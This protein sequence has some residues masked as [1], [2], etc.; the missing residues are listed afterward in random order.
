MKRYSIFLCS[1]F[2]LVFT[3]AVNANA[4]PIQGIPTANGSSDQ[5]GTVNSGVVD[6]F[7]PLGGAPGIY[8][9]S[10]YGTFSDSASAQISGPLMTMYLYFDIPV[11]EFGQSL[12]LD[13][14][15]LDLKNYN[16]PS[17]FFEKLTL[18][19]GGGLPSDTFVY[20]DDL[21]PYVENV[22][23]DNSLITFTGLNIQPGG[24][25]YWLQLGFEAYSEGLRFGTWTNTIERMTASIETAPVPEPATMLLLG[26]GLIGLAGIGRKK[27]F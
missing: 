1:L 22:N 3:L 20:Y 7:I 17:G 11:G 5:V 19:G 14:E 8:G 25:D 26:A 16:D 23:D 4:T 18:Y 21:N 10:N 2:L 9:V 6:F 15:D 13:F 27:F 12:T 24:G